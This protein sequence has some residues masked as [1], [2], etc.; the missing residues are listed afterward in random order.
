MTT[1]VK[2][3][4]EDVLSPEI[5]KLL[6]PYM[7]KKKRELYITSSAFAI[8]LEAIIDILDLRVEYVELYDNSSGYIENNVI[9]INKN[10]SENR[11]R[12]TIAH[13]IGHYLFKHN[14]NIK[15]RQEKYKYNEKE[16]K[17]ER[18]ANDFSANLLMPEKQMKALLIKYYKDHKINISSGLSNIQKNELTEFIS[19]KLKVSKIAAEYRLFNLRFINV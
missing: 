18:I 6:K 10:H 8:D 14:D 7:V 9:F 15:Y 11:Q 16:L 5:F 13:E 17:E 2:V 4:Y 12:F 19:K 1:N 3:S